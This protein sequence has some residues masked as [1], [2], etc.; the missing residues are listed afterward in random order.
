VTWGWVC[1]LELLLVLARAVILRSD[2]RGTHD[3]ILLSQIRDS[4]NLQG[5]VPVFISARNRVAQFY[6]QALGSIFIGSYD[7]RDYGGGIQPPLHTGGVSVWMLISLTYV[8]LAVT[9]SPSLCICVILFCSRYQNYN[10]A[11]HTLGMWNFVC[12]VKARILTEGLWE[13]GTEDNIWTEII[14]SWR[15]LHNEELHNLYTWPEII[16]MAK[17]RRMD[18]TGCVGRMG[19]KTGWRAVVYIRDH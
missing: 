8:P 16:R 17:S 19:L 13:Q 5:Q 18:G 4:P 2:S 10:Y 1:S 15:R 6:S 12:N 9:P 3:H 11:F 14:A 7:S